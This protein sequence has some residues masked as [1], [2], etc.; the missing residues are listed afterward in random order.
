MV[1]IILYFVVGIVVSFYLFPIGFTFLPASINTKMVLGLAGGILFGYNSIQERGVVLSRGLLGAIGFA[2]FFSLACYI[3]TDVNNTSDYSYVTY[4][5]SFFAWLA[6]AYA[7][8][9]LIKQVHSTNT[10]Q[11]LVLYLAAVCFVQCV[12]ALLID[13]IESFQ[14]LVDSYVSQG[15]EFYEE[16]NRLYGI[17]A[18]LDSAGVRFA[19]VLVLIIAL[20]C[21]DQQVRRHS[22]RIVLLLVAFFT[23]AVIGNMISRTTVIGLSA[24]ILYFII[25]SGLFRLEIRFSAIHLG[26]WFGIT[27]LIAI[28]IS[29]Y[30][31]YINDDFYGHMRFAFE[32]FFN[33]VEKG[34][35]KTASTD[36]LNNEMWIWPEDTKT[37]IIGS[38]LF[39]SFIY[40]TDIGYCRFILYSGLTGFSIFALFFIYNG[41]FFMRQSPTYATMFLVLIAMTF[42]FWIK[43]ATDI[44]FIYALFFCL[45]EFIEET[46]KKPLTQHEDRLLYS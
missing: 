38:G 32:G 4:I 20:I 45:D 42:L 35:W 7:V 37:W 39:G 22:V 27:L 11:I 18:A 36:K 43:V 29:T 21:H 2:V 13:N 10:F 30:L 5:G 8:C 34:E 46:I 31:Y 25:F 12:L 6:G 24:A 40:G 26:I 14:L 23:V 33:L 44:F 19:V 41:Y 17:G 9:M 3:A 16:K 15:Q 1:R 28:A